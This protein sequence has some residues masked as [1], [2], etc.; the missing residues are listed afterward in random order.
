MHPGSFFNWHDASAITTTAIQTVDNN[1]TYLVVSSFNRGPEEFT[2]VIGNEFYDLYGKKMDFEKHGQPALQAANM[3]DG[4]ARLLVKRVVA[5]DANLANLILVATVKRN[6]TAITTSDDDPDGQTIDQILGRDPV[7]RV[8]ADPLSIHCE[9]GT[10]NNGAILT[11]TPALSEGNRYVWAATNDDTMPEKD[12]EIISAEYTDWDGESEV[13]VGDQTKIKLLEVDDENHIKKCGIIE[14][15][16]KIPNPSTVSVAPDTGLEAGVA[17]SREGSG[18]DTTVITI[19]TTPA[20]GNEYFYSAIANMPTQDQVYSAEEISLHWIRFGADTSKEIS[21][22]DDTDLVFVEF[23]AL[24]SEELKAVKGFSITTCSKREPDT[25]TSDSIDPV[26]PTEKKYIVATSSNT[27][28]WTPSIVDDAIVIDDVEAKAAELLDIN[29]PDII[30]TSSGVVINEAS[31]YPLIC[32]VDNGRGISSKAF[33]IVPDYRTSKELTNMIYNVQILE[34]TNVIEK[35]TSMLNPDG[36]YNG[37]NYGFSEDTSIQVKMFTVPTAYDKFIENISNITGIDES[38][39]IKYDLINAKN[40]RGGD[41]IDEVT[42]QVLISCDPESI[43]IGTAYGIEL[44][45]GSNGAFGD[46]PFGTEAWQNAIIDVFTGEFSDEIWDVDTYKIAAVFDA[47]YP[48]DVKNA[49]AKFVTFREDCSFFRDYGL[50]VSS[51]SSIS[52]Y[53]ESIPAEYKNR[54]ISDYYTTYQIFDPE[55]KRRIHVTMMY[56][57]ARVMVRH[58]ANGC[59]R[60]LAGVANDMILDSAIEG[61]INFTPRITPTTDQKTL[62]D[63]LRVNYAIFENGICVVQSTYT[64]QPEYTQLSFSNNVLAIQEVVRA[65][66]TVCPRQRFTFVSGTDFSVYATAVNE[67][68]QKFMSNFATLEFEYEQ[69]DLQALQKIFYATIKFRFNNW[70]QTEVFE[71]YALPNETGN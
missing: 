46:A 57:F 56:D 62:L 59:Y 52:D 18:V 3:I 45:G 42:K 7:E 70:A 33:R 19:S 31:D 43:N 23:E 61:T 50:E 21:V 69:N 24:E 39:L 71:L 58:F 10:E 55:T 17:T 16:S 6:I 65:V 47:N 12:Y 29:D 36:N 49:I 14:V 26:I 48:I 9:V 53:C 2:S 32:M 28:K 5:N 68:L 27:I 54:Y 4:G 15:V 64:S 20:E 25:R 11:V 66:R 67:V 34:G 40:N 30:I 44:E 35:C 60:P 37:R 63:N 1:P 13:I 41:I 38:T 22:P 51:Y 8:F